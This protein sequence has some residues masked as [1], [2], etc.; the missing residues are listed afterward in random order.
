MI[1]KHHVPLTHYTLLVLLSTGFI[2]KEE[3]VKIQHKMK[4][5]REVWSKLKERDFLLIY[6]EKLFILEKQKERKEEFMY[7]VRQPFIEI[8]S[9]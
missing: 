2:L 8:N 9:R 3:L 6:H 4:T 5:T 7:S 1:K